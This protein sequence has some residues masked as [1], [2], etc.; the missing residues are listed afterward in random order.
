[1]TCLLAT[2][3]LSPAPFVVGL[4]SLHLQKQPLGSLMGSRT[5]YQG[6]AGGWLI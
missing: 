5:Y 3:R 1:M 6:R 4:T 2:H